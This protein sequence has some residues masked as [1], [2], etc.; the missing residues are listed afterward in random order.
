MRLSISNIAWDPQEDDIIASLLTRHDVD[1]IDVAPGKY[2]PNP[3]SASDSEI[4]RIRQWWAE[5]GIE[6]VG[7][8]SLLF[9]TQGLN[10][11]GSQSSQSEM[12]AH[13]DAICRIG[14]GLGAQHLVFGSPK[15]RDR[16]A[17]SDE[18][19]AAVAVP[20][21]RKLA[22]IAEAH[23][24]RVCLE[25]NPTCYGANF[26][27]N[28]SETAHIVRAVNHPAIKMQFD[29][30]ALAINS[31]AAEDVLSANADVIGH[32]HASEPQLKPLGDGS[33]DL[34]AMAES[35]KKHFP[36][37]VIAIE[38]VATSDEPHANSIERA[39][40]TALRHFRADSL[41]QR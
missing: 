2:F 34:A 28:S 33:S 26:M 40:Q 30:G 24:V 10:L 29:S 1:A 22:K 3:F 19:A 13:L 39:I 6:I 36:D 38:M 18:E 21:F 15:N 11:F 20:F 32:I 27:V 16:G 5:K 17:L 35:L 7:M 25:P 4:S 37:S 23:G 41:V 12:L 31:E 14:S 9:G 8:Q